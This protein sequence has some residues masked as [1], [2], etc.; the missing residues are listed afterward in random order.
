MGPL[1]KRPLSLFLAAA[2]AFAP[3]FTWAQEPT[4]EDDVDITVKPIASQTEKYVSLFMGIESQEQLS[5]LPADANFRGDFRKIVK[6]SLARDTKTLLFTPLKEG[7][8]TLQIVDGR[9]NQVFEYRI[10]VK[11]SNLTKVARE[12]KALLSDIEGIEIKIINNRVV[13][14][15]LIWLPRDKNRIFSVVR[16]YD[17]IASD[18]TR[19]N[20]GAQ[21]KIAQL[22]EKDI[23]NPE[24]TVRAVNEKFL[25]EGVAG[26]EGE[27][28]KAEIIAKTYVPDVVV[29][30][31]VAGG[32][33]K[34]R[35]V[36]TVINLITVKPAAP[37]EPGKII[38]VVVHY[39][40]L[41]KDYSKGFSFSWTPS[42]DDKT[43]VTFSNASDR[44]AAG[45][46]TSITGVVSNLLPKLN[47]MKS[48]GHARV[49]E[50]TTLI[51]QDGQKG[52]LK[53]VTSV[54]FTRAVP[55]VGLQ[56]E[57]QDAGIITSVTPGIL[58]SRSDS[59]RMQLDF[60]ISNLLQITDKGPLIS[61]NNLTTM[62]TVRSG[63]SAAV[64][65][66]ISN[67]TSTDY[68]KLPPSVQNPIFSLHASK[69]F[70]RNQSQF[71]V[72]VTPIIKSSASAGSEK[73]KQKFRLRD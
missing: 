13:V 16:Q 34:E 52:E 71:V 48:H 39:V 56:T 3:T 37:K 51:V 32:E 11:K 61:K 59:V 68:N 4:P 50:S 60:S 45:I 28:Q 58:S 64:G 22:I 47:W 7:L 42:L 21:R 18:L 36:D 5:S 54:P 9:G 62:I 30:A 43:N 65:G 23:G 66:L 55:N 29:Q 8:A 57:F 46:V 19:M 6:V 38:Q 53:S 24:I 26:D 31:A 1:F 17:G 10:D 72:F 2:V 44:G 73:I 67:K 63:Q 15:G 12:I 25:L 20:P 49:L 40:E 41:N 27:K 35:K 70:Q 14:D 33:I 69:Q